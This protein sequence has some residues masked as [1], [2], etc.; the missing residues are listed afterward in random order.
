MIQ[1]R[2]ECKKLVRHSLS[3]FVRNFGLSGTFGCPEI[4]CGG[5]LIF[6]ICLLVTAC[7]NDESF[8]AEEETINVSLSLQGEYIEMSES[9]LSRGSE[10]PSLQIQV[11]QLNVNTNKYEPYAY[12]TFD[13]TSNL[14]IELKKDAKY[15][16]TVCLYYDYIDKYIFCLKDYGKPK[17]DIGIINAF[18]YSN[19]VLDISYTGYGAGPV[20]RLTLN[21]A[22]DMIPCKSFHGVLKD[23]IP[24]ENGIAINML[25]TTIG[26]EVIVEGMTEGRVENKSSI[27]FIIAYPNTEY[28]TIRTS[29]STAVYCG[30]TFVINLYMSYYNSKEEE[31]TL[32]EKQISVKRNHKKTIRIKLNST[33]TNETQNKISFI[34]E[35]EAMSDD[36]TVEYDCNI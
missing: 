6:I 33:S 5:F 19:K 26:L 11:Y 22:D 18:V 14:N 21:Y 31:T 27:P 29:Y 16:F 36:E 34:M 10:T 24:N 25:N 3:L 20:S 15:N 28:S 17:T 1:I 7:G 13:N 30:E 4:K 32:L 23:Y 2:N 35:N 12:G 8:C 9:P